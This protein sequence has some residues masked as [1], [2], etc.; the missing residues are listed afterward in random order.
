MADEN[1]KVENYRD[2]QVY[3][4]AFSAAQDTFR[5]SMCFPPDEK[6]SLTGQIRLASRAVCAHIATAWRKRQSQASF[7]AKMG[8]AY[9]QSCETKVWLEFAHHCQYITEDDYAR[10][11]K[12]YDQVCTQLNEM[13]AE[14]QKWCLKITRA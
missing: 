1:D 3:K 8:D 6:S 10:M 13:I 9:A 12:Q 4:L 11:D 5:L 7:V 14:P 2:L